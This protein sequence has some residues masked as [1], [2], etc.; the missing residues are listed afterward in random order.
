MHAD[1]PAYEKEDAVQAV[2]ADAPAAA[3]VPASH[4]PQLLAPALLDFPAAHVEHAAMVVCA[5]AVPYVPARQYVHTETPAL[6]LHL[7]ASHLVQ[8]AEPATL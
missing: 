7:P 3:Y 4:E 1:A 5:V 2:H 6:A 8:P